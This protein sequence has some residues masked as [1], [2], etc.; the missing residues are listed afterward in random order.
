MNEFFADSYFTYRL[1][2]FYQT[3]FP[4]K[5][6]LPENTFDD[7]ISSLNEVKHELKNPKSDSV[8]VIRSILYYLLIQLNRTY[9][10]QHNI[11]SAISQD[12]TAYQ[13]RMLVEKHIK[14]KQR[15]EDYT[16]LMQT[17]RITLNKMVKKHFNLT[18]TDFIKSRLTF[19]LKMQ[20]IY[21]HKTIAELAD[22]YHFSEPNHLTRFFKSK[23]GF[24]PVQFRQDYQNGSY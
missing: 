4:L 15:V 1:H 24:T 11:T 20:L 14:Q 13:F 23:V 21:T 2:Y 17:S 5:I 3:N 6:Q 19:E 12:N 18:A 9:T 22:E 7:Y 8:H 16:A 10:K